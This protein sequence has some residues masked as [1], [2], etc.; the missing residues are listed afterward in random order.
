MDDWP[1]PAARLRAAI[2]QAEG[3][4]ERGE[5]I[6]ASQT[7]SRVFAIAGDQGELVRA[8]TTW[9]P[10]AASISAAMPAAPGVSSPTPADV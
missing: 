2:W 3:E 6:P 8:F 7:L 5:Y 1:P 4:L 10:P 9:R